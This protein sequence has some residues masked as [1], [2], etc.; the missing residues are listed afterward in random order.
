[1][2]GQKSNQKRIILAV[3]LAAVIV[4]VVVAVLLLNGGGSGNNNSNG[5]GSTTLNWTPSAGDYLEYTSTGFMDVTTRQTIIS[6]TAT[7]YTI[8]QSTTVLGQASYQISTVNKSSAFS[9]Q[10]DP[11]SP[12]SGWTS[13]HAGTETISTKW[14]QKACDK[15]TMAGTSEGTSGSVT[16][17]LR[18]GVLMKEIVTAGGSTLLTMTLSDTNVSAITGQ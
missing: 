15:W 4:V 5:T 18:G 6:E 16:M 11:Q 2:E 9:G 14:G 10:Y 13:D 12:P 17:W 3:I 8:N 1:L 7:T